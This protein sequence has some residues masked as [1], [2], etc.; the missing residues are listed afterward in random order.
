MQSGQYADDTL[1][2]CDDNDIKIALH[3]L[4][5][6]C[7]NL[8]LYFTKYS[9]KLNRKKIELIILNKKHQGRN[10]NSDLSI[11]IADKKLEEK[12]EVKYLRVVLDQFLTFQGEV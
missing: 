2:F 4:Q 6:S 12:P 1:L 3:L 8:S 10:H 5:K 9:L 11:K 7:Q